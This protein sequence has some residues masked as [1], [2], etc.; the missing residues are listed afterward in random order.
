MTA[1][2]EPLVHDALIY[3]ADA[4]LTGALVPADGMGLWLARTLCDRLELRR[5]P[6]GF[7]VR[8]VMADVFA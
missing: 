7:V 3:A 6:R 1:S 8:L 4:E 5:E 2:P